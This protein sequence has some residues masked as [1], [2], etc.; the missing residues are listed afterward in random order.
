MA[1]AFT[2]QV[3]LGNAALAP[4]PEAETKQLE[5]TVATPECD[6]APFVHFFS[7]FITPASLKPAAHH[8]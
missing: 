7:C 2:P 4:Q 6:E 8:R 1:A 5:I 3:V